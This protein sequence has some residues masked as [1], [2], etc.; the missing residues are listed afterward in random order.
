MSR[1]FL[2]AN[3]LFGAAISS[4]GS[5]RAIFEVADQYDGIAL[6]V[7]EYV[8]EEAL[9]NLEDKRAAGVPELLMLLDGIGFVPEP[10]EEL[11]EALRDRV[12]APDDVP[13]LDGAL[14]AGADI[15]VTGNRRHLRQIVRAHQRRLYDGATYKYPGSIARRGDGLIPSAGGAAD[16]RDIFPR[17]GCSVPRSCPPLLRPQRRSILPEP[18]DIGASPIV[19]EPALLRAYEKQERSTLSR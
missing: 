9:T 7:T 11:A 17:R 15:L 18:C 3:V 14:Y 8:M 6:V 16:E 1:V 10:P 19:A 5:A 4:G 13:V 2:D 12:P